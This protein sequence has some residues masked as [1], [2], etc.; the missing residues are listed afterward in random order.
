[1]RRPGELTELSS[2]VDSR[3]GE[4]DPPSGAEFSKMDLPPDKFVL[5][6]ASDLSSYGAGAGSTAPDGH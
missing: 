6:N 2:E 4:I 3:A 5:Q 1:L